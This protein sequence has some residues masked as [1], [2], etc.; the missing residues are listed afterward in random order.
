MPPGQVWTVS[1]AKK[2]ALSYLIAA[3]WDKMERIIPTRC[4]GLCLCDQRVNGVYFIGKGAHQRNA[5][6]NLLALAQLLE[7]L[8][9]E[10]TS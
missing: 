7:K 10:E 3:T 1:P 6:A 4:R 9:G 8:E 2:R 5:C